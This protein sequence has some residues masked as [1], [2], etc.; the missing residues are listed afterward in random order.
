MLKLLSKEHCSYRPRRGEM[1]GICIWLEKKMAVSATSVDSAVP[2][3][4]AL[5]LKKPLIRF[6]LSFS[7]NEAEEW[8]SP[9]ASP[10]DGD[11]RPPL[12]GDRIRLFLGPSPI[13]QGCM[14]LRWTLSP[15]GTCASQMRTL[16]SQGED[17]N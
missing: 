9:A 16:I 2:S 15:A 3:V 17:F 6:F 12:R 7:C 13:S 4:S 5:T 11:T 1:Q 8:R 14:W 10:R